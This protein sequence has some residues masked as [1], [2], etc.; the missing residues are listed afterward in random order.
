V[1]LLI[2][3]ESL[4][5]TA[6]ARH[7][8]RVAIVVALPLEWLS[9]VLRPVSFLLER[10]SAGVAIL[11]GGGS[12]RGPITGEEIKAMVTVGRAE[13]AVE[14]GE[15]EMIRRV[16]EF[17]DRHVR[18]IMTPRP[19]IIWVE[20]G[21]TIRQ[22]LELYNVN[23]HTRF[24][25]YQG[26]IDNVVGIVAVK[27]VMRLLSGGADL[28]APVTESV[29]PTLFVPETKRG[30]ELFDEMR[31]SSDQIAMIVDEFGG[32]AGLVTLKRLVEDIVG[33][34]GDEDQAI[35]DEVV[36]V[37][38]DTFDLDAAMSI[39]D[40][41]DRLG[42]E[43]PSGEYETVAGFVLEQLGSV[44]VVGDQVAYQNLH[45]A[46]TEMRGVRIVHVRLTR[47]PEPEA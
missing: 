45:L 31:T 12:S 13:G 32:V 15:A 5:K 22:F 38:E 23:Y 1:A 28:D 40:F 18:E 11:I 27:D 4:P 41:N 3:G 6:A 35:V 37:S 39:A 24:P 20:L 16:L 33:K 46:V 47:T 10:L 19:E 36:E 17:G 42:V 26:Q 14:S 2:F 21:T 9:W 29:R 7:A 34:V 43:L 25:V 30:Q 8:E 44:P